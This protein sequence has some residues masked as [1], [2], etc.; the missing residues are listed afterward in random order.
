MYRKKKK[1]TAEEKA[2][3]KEETI[4]NTPEM[5]EEVRFTTFVLRGFLLL[6]L[7]LLLIHTST[8]IIKK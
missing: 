8:E 1:V 5:F 3:K 4:K 6:I 2:K 7:N